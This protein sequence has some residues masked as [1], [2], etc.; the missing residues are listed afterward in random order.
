MASKLKDHDLAGIF[1]LIA[2]DEFADLVASIKLNGQ[3]EPIVLFDGKILDGRNRYRACLA[4]KVEPVFEDYTGADP[5]GYVI[6][7]NIRRRHL[8]EAQRSLVGA[9]L[10][11]M[12]EGRPSKETSSIELVSQ[13]AAAD[14]LK[15]GVASIKRA[16]TVLDSAEP[17]IILAVEQGVL[18]ISQAAALAKAEPEFQTA[19]AEKVLEGMKPMEAAREVKGAL[20]SANSVRQPSGK[21]R[22]I[23]ADPPWSYGNTQ[24]DYHTEQRDHYPVMKLDEIMALPVDEWTE[25]DAVLFLWVTSP[26][27][28]E[29]FD[30]IGAWGF[31]YKASFVW[32]K[33][34]HNMGHYNSVR[35]EFVLVCTKGSCQ[36]DER[37][38]F[39]SVVTSD[40]TAHS[41][42]PD[43]FYEI[44]EALY[45]HGAKLE[46]FARRPRKGWK[47]YGHIAEVSDA[48]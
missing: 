22:V 41:V 34:K 12:G 46:M 17:E 9:R 31:D 8:N 13:A 47:Q 27:L 6:D 18:A 40:R 7:L 39:D 36:P 28:E 19:V 24:P 35:H 16:V 25:D 38:L 42:K 43:T 29:A 37:K 48:A 14:L 20:A 10:A 3:R 32:D 33:I 26:M 30:V 4:A 23:Y 11:N 5:L 44:I 2:G 21:Y 45:T 1:P 15:V